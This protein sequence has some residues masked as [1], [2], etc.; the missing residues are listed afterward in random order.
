[1]VDGAGFSFC[2]HILRKKHGFGPRAAF[3][4]VARVYRSGGLAKDAIYL[5][6]FSTVLKMLSEGKD[7]TPFW[8]GKIAAH[9]VPVV[10]ELEL[11]GLLHRP[12]VPPDFLS[13][14]IGRASCRE[15]VCANV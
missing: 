5:R 13:R 1:M 8:F 15:R 6:G 10:E 14:K 2:F 9:H 3:G 11:R 12:R 4:I 7:L